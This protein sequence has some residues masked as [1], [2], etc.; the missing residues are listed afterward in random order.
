MAKILSSHGINDKREL[1]NILNTPAGKMRDHKGE[2]IEVDGFA[3]VE[4]EN[5]QTGE[6]T[7]VF[8]VK[9]KDGEILG[10][11]SKSFV[12]GVK[13]FIDL[14]GADELTAFT[15]G[16]AVSKSGRDYMIFKA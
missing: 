3:F 4:R 8:M 15:V 5:T 13:T 10:T 12:D 16:T 7:E 9:T 6:V 11:S 2:R 1:Y 14:L